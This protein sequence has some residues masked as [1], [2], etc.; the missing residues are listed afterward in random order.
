MY[1]R[2]KRPEFQSTCNSMSRNGSLIGCDEFSF[3][4]GVP[5]AFVVTV[6]LMLLCEAGRSMPCAA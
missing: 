1:S 4:M 5:L 6:T 3:R 2:N